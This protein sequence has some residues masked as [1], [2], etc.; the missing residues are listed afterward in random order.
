MTEFLTPA[1]HDASKH[2]HDPYTESGARSVLR[3]FRAEM[4]QMLA[5]MARNSA[6][7]QAGKTF[8]AQSPLRRKP[9]VA[10]AMKTLG[11]VEEVPSANG[12][13]A[14]VLTDRGHRQIAN[15][16]AMGWMESS[17]D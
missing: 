9:H 17:D 13:C 5:L 1:R 6:E 10:A 15:A 8:L 4:L 12:A 7:F 16:R 3:R 2:Y 14:L 11:W